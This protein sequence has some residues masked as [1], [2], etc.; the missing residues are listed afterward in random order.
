VPDQI[1]LIATLRDHQF[2]LTRL[3]E[4]QLLASA[5]P[6][7][8]L[9]EIESQIIATKRVLIDLERV[10]AQQKERNNHS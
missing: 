1:R 5:T 6:M 7:E 10:V 3:L 2:Q 4:R 8:T 9:E